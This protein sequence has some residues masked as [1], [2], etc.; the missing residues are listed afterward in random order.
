MAKPY[1]MI[2][3]ALVLAYLFSYRPFL[4][5]VANSLFSI[6]QAGKRISFVGLENYFRL[7]SSESFQDSLS[8]TLRFTLYFVPINIA[9]TL[10]GAF[11]CNRKG[12]LAQINGILLFLPLA[13]AMSSAMM[14]FKM[15]FNPSIGIVNSLLGLDIQWFNDSKAAMALLV[16]AGVWLDIGF[17]FL[18]LSSALKNVP[19]ALQEAMLIDGASK[20]TIFMHLQIPFIAPTLLFV[21]CN[22]IKDAML[23][24]SPVIILTEG[25][26]FRSTQT[27][28]YQMYLEGF[29]SGNYSLGSAL[30]TVVFTLTFAILLLL[31]SLEKRRVYYQ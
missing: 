7:F 28:V 10:G 27:L 29:K 3:P 31:L 20:R 26:P 22:N 8:N 16:M 24:C 19:P 25:G 9:V 18:L 1:L 14:I 30:A 6:S 5:T 15:L 13:V 21:L 2:I 23:I 17:D 12:K 11:A 4:L